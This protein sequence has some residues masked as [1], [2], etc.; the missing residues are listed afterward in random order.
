MLGHITPVLL[1]FN[2]EEN[3]D[4]TLAHLA[5]AKDI[6]VVDSGSTDGT[7]AN[8]AKFSNARVFH[9]RFD[10]HGNQWRFAVEQTQIG[11]NWILRLDADYQVSDGLVAEMARLDPN[12]PVSAYRIGF[13][14]AIFSHHLVS[15]LY[16]PNTI[17]LRRGCFSVRDEGHTEAWEVNG[18][19]IKLSSRIIHDDWK[20]TGAGGF[21][22]IDSTIQFYT[23]VNILLKPDSLLLDFG[24]GRGANQFGRHSPLP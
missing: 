11:T 4:R 8:V 3:I 22:R 15:S 20:S 14:Y 12:A 1:T 13:D 7:L 17:L 23:W 16:P 18:P 21:S 5:W 10:S 24:A 19:V 9:R 6:V 2:E